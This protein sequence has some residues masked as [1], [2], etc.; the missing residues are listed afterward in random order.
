V[1]KLYCHKESNHEYC[2]NK[3]QVYRLN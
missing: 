1:L 2:K 3:Y